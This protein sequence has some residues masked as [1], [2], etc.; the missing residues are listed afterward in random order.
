[1]CMMVYLAAD[2]PFSSVPWDESAPAFST[3]AL[4]SDEQRV[5]V[6]FTKP[7]LIYVGAHEGCGCGFQLGQYPAEATD[8]REREL[9]RRSLHELAEYLRAELLRSTVIEL[10]ACWDGDQEAPQEHRRELTPSVLE[11][12]H[13]FFLQKERSTVT[14]D[15]A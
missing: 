2:V 10:F 3:S 14:R 7:N 6:Q 1:M 13:F 12:D 5:S 8:T 4:S 11:G 15:A 9:Q